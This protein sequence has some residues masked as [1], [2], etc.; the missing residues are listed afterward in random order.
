MYT[1][2][3]VHENDG[4]DDPVDASGYIGRFFRKY[5]EMHPITE[6]DMIKVIGKNNKMTELMRRIREIDREHNGFVTSTELDDLLKIHYKQELGNKDLKPILKKYAS[7]QNRILIDY[8]GFRD[9]VVEQLKKLNAN[10]N[11]SGLFSEN[12][13]PP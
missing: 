13:S 11:A 10:F 2:V 1:Q 12:N 5:K 8:K 7:I 6:E 3:D 4:E 9:S